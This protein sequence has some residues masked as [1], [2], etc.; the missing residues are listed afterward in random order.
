MDEMSAE[1]LERRKDEHALRGAA[2]DL[3]CQL[4]KMVSYVISNY[5]HVPKNQ[6]NP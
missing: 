4:E 2:L 1:D 6:A 3:S 5:F